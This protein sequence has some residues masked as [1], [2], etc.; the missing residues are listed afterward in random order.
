MKAIKMVILGVDPGLQKTGFAVL[1]T[2]D[3]SSNLLQFGLINTNSCH[4]FERRLKIIYDQL[5]DIIE[6]YTLEG[7][8]L[9]EIFYSRNVKV[10]LKMSHARGVTLLAAANYQ[11]PT[12][13]YSPRE[14]KQAVTGN[15]NASKY[16]V[17]QMIGRLLNLTATPSNFDITDAMAVAYCHSQRVIS[18]A[19]IKT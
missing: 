10:A 3:K 9:E 19:Q 11:I 17:Q 1:H 13:E 5:C 7:I 2:E 6:Q 12:A 15:G 8:A 18:K 4:L 14:I 16:Q